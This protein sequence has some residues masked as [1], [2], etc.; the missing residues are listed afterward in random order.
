MCKETKSWLMIDD[1]HGFGVLGKNGAGLCD[2]KNLDQHD[3]PILLAT[4]GKAVGVSGAFIAGS[5]ELVETLIQRARSYIF[6]TAS[7]PAI[8]AAVMQSID[9]IQHESWRRQ[10]LNDLIGYF[11]QHM[12]GLNCHLM[13]SNTAIQPLLIGDNH[14]ALGISQR[15]YDQ[16]I[17]VT[18]IRPPTVPEGSARL[19]FTLSA[20]HEIEDIVILIKALQGILT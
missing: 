20:E 15:L 13:P 16:G 1:A 4:L 18:A 9:I 3:V 6:T 17:L 11:K 12:Q 7:P 2:E 10:K 8:A 14:E 5:E 19:R